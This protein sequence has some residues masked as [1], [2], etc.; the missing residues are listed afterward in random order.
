M[1]KITIVTGDPGKVRELQAMAMGKLD[2]VMHDVDIDEIQSLDLEEI[3]RD[4][5]RKAYE[6]IKG[7]VIVDDVSAG[8]VSL[9]GLPGPF[10]KFFNKT[11]G[12]DALYI[13][14]KSEDKTVVISCIAAY[15]DGKRFILGKGKINGKVVSPRGS[16]GF[17]FDVVVIPEGENRTMAEISEE[18]KMQVSHR[19]GAFRSL[20]EQLEELK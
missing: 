9:K 4:K 8:L 12:G 15:F 7:P 13:L 16:N 19:G 2:F 18:E 17:G 1:Q 11:L 5:A 10:I 3:V 20:L 6:Q 14:A